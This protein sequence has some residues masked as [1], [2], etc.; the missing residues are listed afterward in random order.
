M[1]IMQIIMVPIMVL[2]T[3]TH[4]HKIDDNYMIACQSIHTPRSFKIHELGL[5]RVVLLVHYLV[6]HILPAPLS[7]VWSWC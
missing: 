3:H 7:Y 6:F 5:S 2:Y 4:S 1:T